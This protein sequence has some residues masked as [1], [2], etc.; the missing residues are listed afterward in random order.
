MLLNWQRIDLSLKNGDKILLDKV[1]IARRPTM[2]ELFFKHRM[3]LNTVEYI[4]DWLLPNIAKGDGNKRT[5]THISVGT[6][7]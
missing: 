2:L 4:G 6:N 7:V 3:H 1:Q 5:G